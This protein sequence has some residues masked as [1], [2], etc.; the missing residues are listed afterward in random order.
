MSSHRV[1]LRQHVSAHHHRSQLSG[2]RQG[3]HRTVAELLARVLATCGE[4]ATLARSAVSD[5][6]FTH[7]DRAVR[8]E[9]A[10]V[11]RELH[12][13]HHGSLAR[14]GRAANDALNAHLVDHDLITRQE[15]S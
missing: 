7:P 10:A 15:H 1:V 6:A 11:L 2:E 12:L 4:D 8:D 3:V 13:P 14:I 9:L 5:G